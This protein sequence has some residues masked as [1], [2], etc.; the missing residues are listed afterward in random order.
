VTFL[1]ISLS[2]YQSGYL[3]V[4]IKIN[5]YSLVSVNLTQLI[6]TSHFIYVKLELRFEVQI[7]HLLE[8]VIKKEYIFP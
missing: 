5:I 6:E 8:S 7:F 4:N 1:K 2:N 3:L